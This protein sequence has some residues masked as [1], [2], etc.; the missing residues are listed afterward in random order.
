MADPV[1]FRPVAAGS[2]PPLDLPSYRSTA[3]RHPVAAPVAIPTTLTEASAPRFAAAWYAPHDDL[4]V[5]DG[6]AAMGERIVVAGP[7]H[8]REWPPGAE[9]HGRNLAGERVRPVP[10]CAG[11]A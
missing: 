7:R 5:V 2:Q 3:K 9:R 4:S 8:R 11:P 1:P 6:R 10:S